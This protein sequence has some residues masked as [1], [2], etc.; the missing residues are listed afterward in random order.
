MPVSEVRSRI[1]DGAVSDAQTGENLWHF[2]TNEQF[3]ASPMTYAVNGKQ[4]VGVA[5]GNVYY[6]F[7]LDD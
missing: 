7:A 6:T 2:H 1:R 5:A 3:K 4:Y